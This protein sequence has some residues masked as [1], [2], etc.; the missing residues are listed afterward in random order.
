MSYKVIIGIIAAI[1]SVVAYIPY[2]KNIFKHTTKPHLFTW[3]VWSFI[4]GIAFVAQIRDGAGFGALVTGVTAIICILITFF[5]L[6][7]GEK[8]IKIIDW[9]CLILSFVGLLSWKST[10][11]PLLA[12]FMV[13]IA[14]ILA[15]APTLRKGY[16]KPYEDTASTWALNSIKFLI[17]LIALQNYNLTTILYPATLV[18]SNGSLFFILLLRRKVVPKP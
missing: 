7:Y 18:I 2:F 4:V 13:T 17:S 9:V 12:V 6:F 10:N 3:L 14:D 15:F 16:Y 1:I 8:D 11:N 5:S